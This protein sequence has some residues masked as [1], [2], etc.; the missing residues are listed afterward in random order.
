MRARS[1]RDCAAACAEG[2]RLE[3]LGEA[4]E[5]CRAMRVR[6]S[7]AIRRAR[8]ACACSAARSLCV[9]ATTLIPAQTLAGDAWLAALGDRPLGDALLER[10]G[11]QRSPFEFARANP[12]HPLFTP[13]LAG[14]RH[15]AG[16]GLGAA[17]A[18]PAGGGT[19]AD[20]RDIPAGPD[21]MPAG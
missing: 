10:G 21:P 14:H 1:L 19:A 3:L 13:A 7:R 11:I 9:C 18:L 8:A 16:V 6:C 20:L 12:A 4:I 2:F 15:P 17:L 5:P